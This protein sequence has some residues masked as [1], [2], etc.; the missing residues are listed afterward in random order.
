MKKPMAPKIGSVTYKVRRIHMSDLGE[1]DSVN[2][3]I[4]IN[5]DLVEERDDEVYIHEHLHAIVREYG[6][7][8]FIEDEELFV[9]LLT[10]GILQLVR[11]MLE[12]N[13]ANV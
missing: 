6:I 7:D 3:E 10:P 11:Q 2:C 13:N 12:V 8:H 1:C 9:T 4:N 5:T